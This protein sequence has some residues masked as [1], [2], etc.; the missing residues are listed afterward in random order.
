MPSNVFIC[1]IYFEY[2]PTKP[3]TKKNNLMMIKYNICD[4]FAGKFLFILR[5]NWIKSYL[6]IVIVQFKTLI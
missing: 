1:R 3:R 6:V 4:V 2:L 5:K